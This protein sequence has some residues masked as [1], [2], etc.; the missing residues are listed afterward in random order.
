[1]LRGLPTRVA[2]P[3]LGYD[4]EPIAALKAKQTI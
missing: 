1:M 4:A 3:L 2:P